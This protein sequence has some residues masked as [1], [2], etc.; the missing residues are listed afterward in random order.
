MNNKHFKDDDRAGVFIIWAIAAAMVTLFLMVAEAEASRTMHL[1]D[2][3]VDDGVKICV[4]SDG[5]HYAE[6]ERARGSNCPYTH[7]EY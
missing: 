3:Y 5:R 4:Y 6:V 7:I 2:E 1:V